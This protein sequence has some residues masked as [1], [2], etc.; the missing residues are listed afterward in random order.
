MVKDWRDLSVL[1]VGCGSIG[2]RHA[3]VLAGLG[4][5]DL[6]ACD[7]SADQRVSLLAQVPTVKLFKSYEDGLRGAPG[8][9][10]IC[11][12]PWL[13]IPQ[14]RQAIQASCHVLSEKPLSDSTE[15]I[16]DLIALAEQRGKK[17]MVGLC[18]R[19]HTGLVKAKSYLDAGKIGRLVSVRALVGEHLPLARPDY[20]TLFSSQVGGAFDLIHEIDLMIW[21]A[22]QP[23][24][25]V[26]AFSGAYSDIGITA[27]DVAEILVQFQDRCLASVHLDFFQYPRRRQT[28]L[29][30]TRGSIIIEFAHWDHCTVSVYEADKN[31]W[32]AE[33]MATDRDDMFRA[34]DQEFLQAVAEDLPIRCTLAEARKSVEVELAAQD[35]NYRF[36][37][38]S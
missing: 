18:F 36:P 4:V 35:P 26:H 1:I 5:K 31:H 25:A 33:D 11:T 27:P 16:D 15:G 6:R 22:G 2:K 37:N 34:E 17:V 30:G 13:H 7:P 9:V 20:R 10:L 21:Y 29:M 12:P 3:R 32:E 28:E 8:T 14:A 19:Y 23:V 24:S 38:V